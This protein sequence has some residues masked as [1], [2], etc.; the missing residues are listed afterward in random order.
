MENYKLLIN[1]FAQNDIEKAREYFNNKKNTL[2]E[3]FW[4]EVKAKLEQIE[5]NPNQFQII[6]DEARRAN[7]KRFPFGIFYIVKDLIINVFGVIHF[8]RSP[9]L[10]QKRVEK[11][12]D[13]DDK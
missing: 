5:E 8:S 2:G 4:K 11:G 9:E 1:H 13:T 10:W 3:E 7:L 12:G 6:V